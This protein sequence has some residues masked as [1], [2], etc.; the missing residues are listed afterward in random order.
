LLLEQEGAA[1]ISAGLS[2]RVDG[3]Y[4][5]ITLCGELDVVDAV[6]VAAAPGSGPVSAA[7]T[8]CWPRRAG[9]KGALAGLAAVFSVRTSLAGA[10]QT[11]GR[12]GPDPRVGLHRN[13]I[14]R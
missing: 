1:I 14:A 12:S 8:C 10:A 13:R 5:I 11:G 3:G 6:S 7:V 9:R 4:L 2:T